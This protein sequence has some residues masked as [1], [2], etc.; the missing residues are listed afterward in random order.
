MEFNINKSVLKLYRGD[1]VLRIAANDID[2]KDEDY[3]IYLGRYDDT[4]GKTTWHLRLGWDGV[5]VGRSKNGEITWT[6][7]HNGWRRTT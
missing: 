7:D 4:T 3:G 6:L 2:N 5:I 1:K